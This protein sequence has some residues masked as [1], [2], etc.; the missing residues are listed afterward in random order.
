MR[1]VPTTYLDVSGKKDD[2]HASAFARWASADKSL[3]P[4]YDF[5]NYFAGGWI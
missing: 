3:C 4:P 2:G 5:A 1:A